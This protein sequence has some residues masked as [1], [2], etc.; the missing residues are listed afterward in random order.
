MSESSIVQ[1][2]YS[3]VHNVATAFLDAA[4]ALARMLDQMD[5]DI[6]HTGMNTYWSG[7]AQDEY[8]QA[9]ANWTQAITNMTTA[10]PLMTQVLEEAAQAYNATDTNIALS[11]QSIR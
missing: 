11:W 5:Q 1:V 6:T 10:L 2:H 3:G 7:A 4:Q 8:A 9:K